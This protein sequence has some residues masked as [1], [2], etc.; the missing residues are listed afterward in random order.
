VVAEERLTI[1]LIEMRFAVQRVDGGNVSVPLSFGAG[2]PRR[3]RRQVA[4]AGLSRHGRDGGRGRGHDK[5]RHAA[6]GEVR[7]D[8]DVVDEEKGV[9]RVGALPPQQMRRFGEVGVLERVVREREQLGREDVG[10]A[11]GLGGGGGGLAARDQAQL[12]RG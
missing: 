7:G 5:A 6:A 2:R 3:L 9:G 10:D 4:G 11:L 1:P 12:L 8:V